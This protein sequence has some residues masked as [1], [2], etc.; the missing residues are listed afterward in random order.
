MKI[1][2]HFNCPEILGSMK[3]GE[4]EIPEGATVRDLF[5]VCQRQNDFT[6]KEEHVKW[7][8]VLADGK[9]AKWDAVLS[10]GGSVHIIRG[11]MGG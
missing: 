5:L 4:Y 1:K 3:N 8:L 6:V 9:Q 7:L 11:I 2:V 10:D